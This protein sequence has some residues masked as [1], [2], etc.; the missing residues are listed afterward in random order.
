[1]ELIVKP[2]GRCNFACNFCSADKLQTTIDHSK[3]VPYELIDIIKVLQP[4]H[5]I[6]NGGDPLLVGRDY[7]YKLLDL[8]QPYNTTL[9]IVTN[10]RDFKRRPDYWA[11]LF[12]NPRVDVTTSFQYGTGRR[13]S[14]NIVYDERMFRDTMSLFSDVAG[15]VPMFIAVIT[16]E[17]QSQAL[18]HVYLAKELETTCRL[19]GCLPIGAADKPYPK[20]KMVDL[21]LDI[22]NKG[23]SKY[24]GDSGQ[25]YNGACSFNTKLMCDSTIRVFWKNC[26]GSI[27]YSTCDNRSM[28][29]ADQI[30][31]DIEK[32]IPTK[33]TLDPKHFVVGTQCLSC[34][35]CR[36]CNACVVNRD[37]SKQVPNYCQ[38]MKKRIPAII[39]SGWFI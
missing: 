26:D 27:H 24:A 29:G 23:L 2:T 10:L 33:M 4:N 7:F 17:N 20:Y 11:D 30:P 21:W 38:E 18:D 31:L 36:F 28:S 35:L 15:Y 37:A 14:K 13:W 22:E 8:S 3:D 5:I 16:E 12:N 39:N 9:S 25:M 34:K 1:M 32:P 19:N 6:L